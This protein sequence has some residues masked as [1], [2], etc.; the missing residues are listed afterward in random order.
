[1]SDNTDQ[2]ITD[3]LEKGLRQI[4]IPSHMH[5]AIR[6]HV[7]DRQPVGDFL[8]AVLSNDLKEAVKRADHLNL[9]ALVPWVDLLY[10]Y[11]PSN[12][13]GSPAKVKAWLGEEDDAG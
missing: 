12:C 4:A 5:A 2:W 11:C 7:I 3:D 10:N 9:T 13:W 6:C 8:T 1:M